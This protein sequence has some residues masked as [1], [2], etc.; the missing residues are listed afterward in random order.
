MT[1]R[2][3][4]LDESLRAYAAVVEMQTLVRRYSLVMFLKR[5]EARIPDNIC[6]TIF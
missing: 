4:N 1:A 3:E 5:N 6:A 2:P